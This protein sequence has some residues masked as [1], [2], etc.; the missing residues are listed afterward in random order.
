MLLQALQYLRAFEAIS[1][2]VSL[3]LTTYIAAKLGGSEY[4]YAAAVSALAF[5][6]QAILIATYHY[7]RHSRRFH[8]FSL[9]SDFILSIL[10]VCAG[11]A[12]T[13]PTSSIHEATAAFLYVL[14]AVSSAVTF[15]DFVSIRPKNH[16]DEESES[17]L[18]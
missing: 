5:A 12:A 4:R 18:K 6:V 2:I 17:E 10:F 14:F 15:L 7:T 11:V 3:G 13:L 9:V 8:I 16:D 1:A